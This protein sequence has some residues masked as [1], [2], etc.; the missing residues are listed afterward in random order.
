MQ[1]KGFVKSIPIFRNL[2]MQICVCFSSLL[3]LN[4]YI[5]QKV[6]TEMLTYYVLFISSLNQDKTA[7]MK[8]CICV[9]QAVIDCTY[10]SYNL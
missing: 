4:E 1:S 8:N 2:H 10:N 6:Q 7:I 9:L 3:L 5:S